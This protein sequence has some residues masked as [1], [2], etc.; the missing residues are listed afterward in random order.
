MVRTS[1]IQLD[2]DYVALY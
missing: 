2:D 1:Y